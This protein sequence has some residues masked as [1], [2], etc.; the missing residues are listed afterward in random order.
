MFTAQEIQTARG[1]IQY[2]RESLTGIQCRIS[3]VRLKRRLDADVSMQYTADGCPFCPGKIDAATPTFDGG[4]RI[5]HGESVTF[6][7][8]YPYSAVHTVTVITK[9]HTVD[10]FRKEQLSDAFLGMIES[11]RGSEGYQSIN[12]NNLPSAGASLVHPHL[13][14][15]VDPVPSYLAGRYLAGSAAYLRKHNRV[16]WDDLRARESGS[17]RFLFEDDEIF[18]SASPVPLGEREVRGLLPI[19]TLDEL[20]PY[21][22]PLVSG[23][24]TVID[25]YRSLGTYAFNVALFFDKPGHDRGYRAFCSVISRINPNRLCICDSAFMERLH[26]E[27]V[28]LTLPEDLGRL[29][30]EGRT[31]S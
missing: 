12:W 28:I 1:T 22:D 9:A 5:L 17:D 18:W 27:P 25:L 13:Q 3:P 19:A 15:I 29:F 6:P 31:R 26:Q 7:N 11:L 30:R 14:G 2:R 23:L 16:Y 24:L 4:F 8:L 10:R 21:V 20:E